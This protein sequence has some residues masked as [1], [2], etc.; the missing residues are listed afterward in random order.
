MYLSLNLMHK[1]SLLQLVK[2]RVVS[3]SSWVI[4]LFLKKIRHP[5]HTDL[6]LISLEVRLGTFINHHNE[7]K[8]LVRNLKINYRNDPV[9]YDLNFLKGFMGYLNVLK[10]LFFGAV[11]EYFNIGVY[12]K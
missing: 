12:S 10:H 5:E 8:F 6:L 2:L 1:S 9:R 4:V 3:E 11:R 7:T